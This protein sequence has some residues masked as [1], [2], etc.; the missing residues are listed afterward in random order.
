MF[1]LKGDIA[2][3]LLRQPVKKVESEEEAHVLIKTLESLMGNH[4]SVSGPE[5]GIRSA[6]AIIRLPNYSLNLINSEI[7]SESDPI[8]SH[9]ET[10]FSFPRL[11][12]NCLRYENV[13]LRNGLSGEV[14][15]LSGKAALLAQHHVN[16]L[17]GVVYHDRMIKL[18]EVRDD[19]TVKN[20]DACPC[21]SKRKF[22]ECCTT[23]TCQS[24]SSF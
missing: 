4:T 15:Q 19:N 14:V 16:H 3:E 5:L 11:E 22:S 18:A 7:I 8:I 12:L 17:H 20:S 21:G 24:I 2:L 1:A 6:V 23:T 9:A 13:V 10:C